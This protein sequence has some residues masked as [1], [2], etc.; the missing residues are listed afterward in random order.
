MISPDAAD[1]MTALLP[2]GVMTRSSS[3]ETLAADSEKSSQAVLPLP[4][5]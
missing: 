1:Q 3:E 4:G 5:M 2:D